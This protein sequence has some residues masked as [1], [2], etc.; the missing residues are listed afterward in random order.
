MMAIWSF[1]SNVFLAYSV[2]GLIVAAL[3]LAFW[4]VV[5]PL[6]ILWGVKID[7]DSERQVRADAERDTRLFNES[8]KSPSDVFWD[9]QQL[10]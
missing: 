9:G 5:G 4:L 8:A 6:L 10:R 3:T 1:L 2:V 7:R